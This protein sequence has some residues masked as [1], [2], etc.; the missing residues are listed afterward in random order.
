MTHNLKEFEL[1]SSYLLAK[2]VYLTS[3]A[4]PCDDNKEKEREIIRESL[5]RGLLK[6]Y[7]EIKKLPKDILELHKI[8]NDFW[9][10]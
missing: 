4:W 2:R 7:L 3:V 9:S 1:I 10:K 6:L 8:E 5:Y